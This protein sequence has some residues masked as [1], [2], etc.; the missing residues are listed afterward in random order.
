MANQDFFA[1]RPAVTPTI[2]VYKLIGVATHE[3]FVKVGYVR[4]PHFPVGRRRTPADYPLHHDTHKPQKRLTQGKKRRKSQNS[5][6]YGS[7]IKISG[8]D[9]KNLC[10]ILLFT[11]L[12]PA[13]IKRIIYNR[14]FQEVFLWKKRNSVMNC[15]AQ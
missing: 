8:G 4:Q 6:K 12:K 13:E 11:E 5:G 7:V 15:S 3:G 14:D 9:S 10:R 2:Y 1:Q